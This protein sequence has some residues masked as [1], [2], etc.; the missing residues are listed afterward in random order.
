MKNTEAEPCVLLKQSHAYYCRFRGRFAKITRE[1]AYKKSYPRPQ[2]D[3]LRTAPKKGSNKTSGRSE[4][5]PTKSTNED[6]AEAC[7]KPGCVL[8]EQSQEY[9]LQRKRIE[10]LEKLTATST[11]HSG[12]LEVIYANMSTYVPEYS[13]TESEGS[14]EPEDPEEPH[15]S[16]HE[17]ETQESEDSEEADEA[18]QTEKE[19]Q[20]PEQ[21][22]ETRGSA[23]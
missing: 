17:E 16:K 5:H 12:P 2:W 4:G 22:E 10:E 13:D 7:D 20:E 15:K 18:Q 8:R 9:L 19:T 3:L 14:E 11:F 23:D 1:A 21:K 6:Q